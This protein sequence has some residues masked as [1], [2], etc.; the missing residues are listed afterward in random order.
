[1]DIG[2]TIAWCLPYLH[3]WLTLIGKLPQVFSM[4]E[5]Q[6]FD[7]ADDKTKVYAAIQQDGACVVENFISLIFCDVLMKDFGGFL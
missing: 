2:S 1:M 6:H 3:A 4:P 5:L 7:V